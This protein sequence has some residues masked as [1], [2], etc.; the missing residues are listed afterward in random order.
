ME[1][2]MNSANPASSPVNVVES[3]RAVGDDEVGQDRHQY[4]TFLIGRESYAIGILRIKEIIEYAE[5][6]AVP[7]MPRCV[8]G[9]INLRGAVVPVLDLASRFGGSQA[10]PTR[11]TC[12]VIVEIQAQG[13]ATQDVGVIVDAVNE[14]VEIPPGEIE[15]PPSFGTR[16]PENF[17]AGMGKLAGKFVIVLD[18]D[19]VL[20]T[21][22]IVGLASVAPQALAA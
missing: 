13:E 17:I 6:T 15:P 3:L 19:R 12:I 8:R 16:I 14:V 10:V 5:L 2:V 9:V 4:L 18:V 7:M 22:D 11:R 21:D 20:S 1:I